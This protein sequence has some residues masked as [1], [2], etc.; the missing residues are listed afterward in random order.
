M[1]Q[2]Y[3]KIAKDIYNEVK[4]YGV[5]STDICMTRLRIKL[6]NKDV[7]LAKFKKIPGVMGVIATDDEFQFVVGP[8]IVKRV[9]ASFK[10]LLDANVEVGSKIATNCAPSLKEVAEQVKNENKSKHQSNLVAVALSKFAK[11]FTPLIPTFIAAGIL[12]GVAGIL[13]SVYTAV[14][15][16]GTRV[17]VNV[18]AGQ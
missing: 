1:A 12:A 3:D 2:D 14:D 9:Y 11:I 16:T 13:Q 5:V 7:D 8:G 6:K 10:P 15:I 4:K 18:V 17:W